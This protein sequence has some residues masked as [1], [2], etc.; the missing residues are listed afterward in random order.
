MDSAVSG[1]NDVIYTL[2]NDFSNSKK[3]YKTY[4]SF[5]TFAG[6][7]FL[8][9]Y[10]LVLCCEN[11]KKYKKLNIFLSENLELR[12]IIVILLN[13]DDIA[14]LKTFIKRFKEK[15]TKKESRIT[16]P[17]MI[18]SFVLTF[19]MP[20]VSAV[21]EIYFKNNNIF[22]YLIIVIMGIAIVI[23]SAL[24]IKLI[25][26]EVRDIFATIVSKYF[27]HDL[28]T[29]NTLEDNLYV[30]ENSEKYKNIR[31]DYGNKKAMKKHIKQLINEYNSNVDKLEKW[32]LK[33]F[34]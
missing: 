33:N 25:I 8:I 16:L 10:I 7:T 22:E 1:G 2:G 19:I 30:L 18:V 23:M 11:G 32:S 28:K 17:F 20:F 3:S 21:V 9:L 26:E 15:Q 12:N 27:K 4:M 31:K 5:F 6:I 14:L 13:K 29:I 24:G 34:S